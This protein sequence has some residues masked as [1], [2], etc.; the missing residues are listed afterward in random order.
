MTKTLAQWVATSR[1]LPDDGR[2]MMA[3]RHALLDWTGVAL[4]GAGAQATRII[5]ADLVQDAPEGVCCLVGQS[6]RTNAPFAA[7]INGVASHVLDFDDINKA[8]RGHPSVTIIPAVLAMAGQLDTDCRALLEAIVIGTE[9]ACH[10]GAMMGADHYEA[11]WHTTAT[12]GTIG[13]AA[14]VSRLLGLDPKQT[15][16]AIGIAATQAA[17]LKLMFGTMCKPLHA[18]K[19]AMS[20]LL[21]AR[22]A[23]AGLDSAEDALEAPFGFGPVLSTGFAAAPVPAMPGETYAIE[24][25]IYK[26][27]AAC[28]Y[29]HS[30]I[31]ALRSLVRDHA[32][33]PAKI[34]Q[35]EVR[36]PRQHLNVIGIK[37]PRTGLEAKFS[38][39]WLLASVLMGI[40]TS[41]PRVFDGNL[42]ARA[43]LAAM[44]ARVVV[45]GDAF[46]SRTASTVC[47]RLD[48]GAE[49]CC[50]LDVGLPQS[51]FRR[52]SDLLSRKFLSLASAMLGPM[53]ADA[54]NRQILN[55]DSGTSARAFGAALSPAQG[56]PEQKVIS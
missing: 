38:V 39:S 7:M 13:A 51:D 49:L 50:S 6:G 33:E 44:A 40:D 26:F 45:L 20:G 18:G 53:R 24:A 4:T 34:A 36:V 11:G 14:G 28:Y 15:E 25:N 10:V 30:A 16:M 9:A 21:S 8:M 27:H 29:T 31:E 1:R 52:Q 5:A 43:D 23:A 12:V 37:A 54:L 41:D 55:L 48:D 19:A 35:I 47:L 3:A 2:A 22:W 56:G 32:P 42:T 17:G 46:D